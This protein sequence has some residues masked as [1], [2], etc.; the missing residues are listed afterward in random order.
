MVGSSS[1]I[2]EL[3]KFYELVS[4]NKECHGAIA[5]QQVELPEVSKYGIVEIEKGSVSKIK[6]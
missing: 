3:I 6:I 2:R 5:V 4:Q 1:G